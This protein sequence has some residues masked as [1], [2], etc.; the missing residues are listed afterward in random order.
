MNAGEESQDGPVDCPVANIK[1]ALVLQGLEGEVSCTEVNIAATA[2]AAAAA[3][4]SVCSPSAS[5]R[6]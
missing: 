5:G 6:K 4:T 3:A 1:I 2:A